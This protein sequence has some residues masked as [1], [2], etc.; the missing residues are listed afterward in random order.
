MQPLFMWS[1]FNYW[2]N[3]FLSNFH[4]IWTDSLLTIDK[5]A[6]YYKDTKIT[7]KSN[8]NEITLTKKKEM[9]EK[10]NY[11]CVLFLIYFL[12]NVDG[13][14]FCGTFGSLFKLRWGNIAGCV[15]I[16]ELNIWWCWSGK[17]ESFW[18]EKILCSCK[19]GGQLHRDKGRRSVYLEK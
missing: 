5:I 7:A 8:F 11:I 17:K 13:I 14:F 16:P 18:E 4:C 9:Q 1:D 10:R 19:L 15:F 2:Q 6:I 12:L 3:R